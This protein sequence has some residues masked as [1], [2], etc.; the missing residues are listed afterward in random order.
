MYNTPTPL[1]RRALLPLLLG[2]VVLW[3]PA[4]RGHDLELT[5]T[6]ILLTADGRFQVDMLVDLD[7]LA[8]GVAPS[9]DSAEL[10]AALSAMDSEELQGHQEKLGAYFARRVRVLFDGERASPVITFPELGTDLAASHG[11][12]SVFGLVARLAGR[13]PEGA[14]AISFRASRS[15]P[16]VH[17]TV[18]D[19]RVGRRELV[20]HGTES[21]RYS[22]A[23]EL[24]TGAGS[25][26]TREIVGQ[27]LT[28]GFW[29]ILP[30]GTDHVLFVLGLFLLSARF[31]PLLWQVTAFTVAHAV[32]LTLSTLGWIRLDP[33]IVEPLIALSIAWVAIEN[34]LTQKLQPW[35]PLM[36]FAFGLLH[37]LGFAGVLGELGLP[38]EERISALLAFNV[39]IELGQLTVLG[40]AMLTLGW[41]RDRPWYRRWLT[42]PLS[43][44]IAVIGLWWF[45]ERL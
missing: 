17:L 10:A 18:V 22:L 6:L 32:T 38:E 33:G 36:V 34:L 40:L 37:G 8:L 42:V 3:S 14:E 43:L 15:F 13:I 19:Q 9:T 7:A 5:E 29:H 12:P 11:E 4:A 24:E 35:R 28:L 1:P 21:R 27:Y 31:R 26:P 23:G 45:I 20:E 30:E 39:G 25:P 44:G 2:L 16:P 41:F